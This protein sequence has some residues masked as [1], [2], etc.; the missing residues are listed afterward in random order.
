MSEKECK[1]K[2]EE[3]VEVTYE[4]EKNVDPTKECEG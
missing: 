3:K 2:C 1:C 4:P